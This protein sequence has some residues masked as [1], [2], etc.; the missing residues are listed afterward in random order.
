MDLGSHYFDLVGWL[1]NFPKIKKI[2]SFCFSN[3][4]NLKNNKKF[5]PFKIYNN[6]ELSTGN[7]QLRN[8]C[9]I[10]YELSYA[11]KFFIIPYVVF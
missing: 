3:I 1:L 9:V 4:T 11:L 7:I 8:D 2:S 10:N 5:T 6:E